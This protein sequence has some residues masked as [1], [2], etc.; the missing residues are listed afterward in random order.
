MRGP[1]RAGGESCPSF[2][3]CL[4]SSRRSCFQGPALLVACLPLLLHHPGGYL[5]TD[6]SWSTNHHRR[7]PSLQPGHLYAR[8]AVVDQTPFTRFCNLPARLGSP[9]LLIAAHLNRASSSPV[10]AAL[11]YCLLYDI[12]TS[13]PQ[14]S[15]I[16]SYDIYEAR[17]EPTLPAD[18]CVKDFAVCRPLPQESSRHLAVI[19]IVVIVVSLLA[20]PQQTQQR[21]PHVR[22]TRVISGLC[23]GSAQIIFAA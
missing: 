2:V 16:S 14:P 3:I 6:L 18:C 19:R 17:H 13:R 8:A 21:R 1:T 20:T 10:R 7:Q 15:S 4:P 11:R 22:P 5:T 9:S 23:A 12:T